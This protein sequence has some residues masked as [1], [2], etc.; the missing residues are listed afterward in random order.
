[1]FA[2]VFTNMMLAQHSP[3]IDQH[4]LMDCLEITLVNALCVK[5]N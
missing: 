3:I 5:I 2:D 1:M 4:L